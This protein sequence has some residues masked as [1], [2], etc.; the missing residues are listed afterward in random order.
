MFKEID[1]NAECFVLDWDPLKAAN[2]STSLMDRAANCVNQW[3][4]QLLINLDADQ[5]TYGAVSKLINEPE[6]LQLL[7]Q[8]L[9]TCFLKVVRICMDPDVITFFALRSGVW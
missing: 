8:N 3:L 5:C 1:V 2:D 7:D 4:C 9:E 6:N